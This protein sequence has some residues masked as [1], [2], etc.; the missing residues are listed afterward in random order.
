MACSCQQ[1]VL[2]EHPQQI[3]LR[4]FWERRQVLQMSIYCAWTCKAP[5]KTEHLCTSK[6]GILWYPQLQRSKLSRGYSL[7]GVETLSW[8]HKR[9]HLKNQCPHSYVLPS[10]SWRYDHTPIWDQKEQQ[11]ALHPIRWCFTPLSIPSPIQRGWPKHSSI[12]VTF[13]RAVLLACLFPGSWL[14]GGQQAG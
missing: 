6:I 5:E 12:S 10:C 14:W 11:V 9:S 1:R 7:D 13:S 2:V 8:R 4:H 3:S